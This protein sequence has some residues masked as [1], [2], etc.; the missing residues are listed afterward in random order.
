MKGFSYQFAKVPKF[1][2]PSG[3]VILCHVRLCELAENRKCTCFSCYT[4]ML[5]SL[6]QSLTS[7][8][9]KPL[10][11]LYSSVARTCIFLWCTETELSIS[12]RSVKEVVLSLHIIRKHLSCNLFILLFNVRLWNIHGNGQQLNWDL[13]NA[14]ISSL[15]FLLFRK[16]AILAKAL[17]FAFALLHIW[18]KWFSKLNLQ[19][20][21]ISNSLSQSLF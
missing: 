19:S 11:N 9:D 10:T 1:S 5:F 20:I 14:L 18:L 8:G 21:S 3:R 4:V 12:K 6:K 7:F 16:G 15:L 17:I 13:K 2:I